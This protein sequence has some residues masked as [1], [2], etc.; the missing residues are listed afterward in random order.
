MAVSV[1]LQCERAAK[2]FLMAELCDTGTLGMIEEDSPDGRYLLR[3]FFEGEAEAAA[4]VARFPAY[5]PALRREETQGW[6]RMA[7]DQWQPVLVGERFYLTPSWRHEPAPPGRFRLPM[8]PGTA[9]GTGLHPATQLALEALERLVH[10]GDSVL[11]LGTGS[12]ILSA[13]ARLLGAGKAIACDIDEQAVTAAR[14]Y[15]GRDAAVFTGSARSLGPESM[16][17]VVANINATVITGLAAEIARVLKPDGRAV[18]G[19]FTG[20]DLARLNPSLQA[21]RLAVRETMS[22]DEWICLLA[23]PE[24]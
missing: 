13:S 2:D 21:A 20:A 22:R 9:S 23:G 4:L 7:R 19:G 1:T 3:V 8:P 15:L 11:D 16:D 5:A 12:G 18:L 6:V 14:E 24:T 17:V 10:P